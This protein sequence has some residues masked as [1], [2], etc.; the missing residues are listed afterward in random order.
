[1][2]FNIPSP[3]T[4]LVQNNQ[5]TTPS[6]N[7]NL[8]GFDFNAP[9]DEEN[10]SNQ[11]NSF[12]SLFKNQN[13]EQISVQNNKPFSSI[14]DEIIQ[15]NSGT[16]TFKSINTTNSELLN[17]SINILPINQMNDNQKTEPEEETK[18]VIEVQPNNTVVQYNQNITDFHRRNL[19]M[20]F[21]GYKYEKISQK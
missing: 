4:N 7:T 10:T 9:S 2:N 5:N 11:N 16:N 18:P 13:S 19:L 3:N 21:V 14:V 12:S 1:M 20:E 15:D 8:F 17:N 6:N